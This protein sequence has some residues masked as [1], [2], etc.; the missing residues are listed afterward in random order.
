MAEIMS[1]IQVSSD[2]FR[3]KVAGN[4]DGRLG[5]FYMVKSP[6]HY[7]L[8]ARPLSIFDL[9]DH[10]IEFLY[11]VVGEGTRIFAGLRR[12]DEIKLTGPLG[13][14]FP[15]H[16]GKS[17]LIGGGI[18]MAPLYYA[19]RQMPEADVYLGFREEAYLMNQFSTTN[20]VVEVKIGGSILDQVDIRKYENIYI[21]GP[22]GM[23]AAA[24]KLQSEVGYNGKMYLSVE[25]RMACGIGACLGCSVKM[26]D[27]NRRACVEGPVFLAKEVCFIG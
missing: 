16:Q 25:N 9:Q 7:P 22:M 2:V 1:N 15:V 20:R 5:Q 26:V 19:S 10:Y 12:G 21:C 14:G 11:Q 4:Y 23:L 24:Q 13:N 18:G 6:G 8:L 3:M 27:G 17:A